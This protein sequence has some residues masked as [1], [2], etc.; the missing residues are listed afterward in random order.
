MNIGQAEYYRVLFNNIVLQEVFI[1]LIKKL[2]SSSHVKVTL[3]I[4]YYK[5]FWYWAFHQVHLLFST[6]VFIQRQRYFTQRFYINIFK[7][8]DWRMCSSSLITDFLENLTTRLHVL[9]T[10][11]PHQIQ[12][13][14]RKKLKI[15][16]HK[17]C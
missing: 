3:Q 14:Y 1:F 10:T 17:L 6:T 2:R 16:V 5:R 11:C 4:L 8:V 13:E 7:T 9:Q 15:K 12:P